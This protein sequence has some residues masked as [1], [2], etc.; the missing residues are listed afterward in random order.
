FASPS[1]KELGLLAVRLFGICVNAASV[2]RLWSSMGFLQT[3]RR[4]CLKADV[5]Y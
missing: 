2:E 1:T 4:C 3:N 5:I